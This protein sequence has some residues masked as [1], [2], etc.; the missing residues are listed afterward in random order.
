MK[1]LMGLI[2]L[3]E[4]EDEIKELTYNRPIASLPIGGR[5]RVIDFILSNLVNTGIEN[6]SI[7]TQGK[8]RSLMDHIRTGKDWDLDR[9]IDGLFILNPQTNNSELLTSNSDIENFKNHM[10]YLERSRQRYVILSRSY[11]ICNIDYKGA[12]EY[13]KKSGADI[14]IIYKKI[15]D[16][17]D[18][19]EGCDTLYLEEDG[20]VLSIGKKFGQNKNNNISM[21]M[22][23]M[24]K[25][26]L[27]DIIQNAIANGNYKS[28]KGAMLSI[29][30]KMNVNSFE[31]KGYLSIVNS[32]KNYYKTNKELL[33]M[34]IYQNLFFSN[35]LIY[36]RV[37]DEPPTNY[38]KN[39]QVIN[40]LVANGCIIEGVV[41][42]SIIFRGVKVKK[43]AVIKDSIIM[44]KCE[45]E[46]GAELKNVI[47][48]KGVIITENKT[49][50]GD[51]E[52]PLV[53]KK[54]TK[55]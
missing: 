20:R 39:A 3:S 2:N 19:F 42:N 6:V 53:I 45:I 54:N 10:V 1:D 18:R 5:Y 43:G 26:L 7:F 4:N 48:D 15:K 35:G 22:Y 50:Y 8:S 51:S 40:S 28:L 49:L 36:T 38:T 25:N 12:Y 34:D 33:N 13:H 32:I 14:T 27:I 11:M 44:Q 9:K 52:N 31:Y 47:L 23:I 29:I 46:E 17:D 55:V 16:Y 24:D 21:E 37:K 30:D 41:E